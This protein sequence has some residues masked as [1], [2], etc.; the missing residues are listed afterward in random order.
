MLLNQ[1][2]VNPKDA[3]NIIDALNVTSIE[4]PITKSLTIPITRM[5]VEYVSVEE[6]YSKELNVLSQKRIIS[7]KVYKLVTEFVLSWYEPV[8]PV[9]KEQDW[10]VVVFKIRETRKTTINDLNLNLQLLMIK[11]F[12]DYNTRT[13]PLYDE[14]WLLFFLSLLF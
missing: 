11:E 13:I 14:R 3:L 8:V 2:T 5:W 4:N 9:N 6:E 10:E 1:K 7:D 12:F